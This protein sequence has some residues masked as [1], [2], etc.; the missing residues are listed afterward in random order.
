[1]ERM[2]VFWSYVKRTMPL[3]DAY[4]MCHLFGLVSK[5]HVWRMP[6]CMLCLQEWETEAVTYMYS[7]ADRIKHMLMKLYRSH[8]DIQFT[9]VVH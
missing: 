5:D 2:P 4:P 9:S 8:I 7:D 1:M 6:C 3:A